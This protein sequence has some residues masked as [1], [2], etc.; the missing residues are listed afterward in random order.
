[1]VAQDPLIAL[2]LCSPEGEKIGLEDVGN[3]LI[4]LQ[5]MVWH[6]GNYMEGQPYSEGGRLKKQ[7]VEDYGLVIK[8]LHSG[9]IVVEVGSQTFIQTQFEDGIALP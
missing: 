6:M 7:I 8:S 4:A 1:M 2:K 9:S 3:L 5:D